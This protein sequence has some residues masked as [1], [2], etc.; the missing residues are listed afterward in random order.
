MKNAITEL[1][2]YQLRKQADN[3]EKNLGELREDAN[4][5][6]QLGIGALCA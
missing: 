6:G 4:T 1:K 5:G 2:M 3:L